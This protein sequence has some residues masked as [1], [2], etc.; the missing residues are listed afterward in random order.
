M[1]EGADRG[2]GNWRVLRDDLVESEERETLGIAGEWVERAHRLIA[3]GGGKHL[4]FSPIKTKR[5]SANGLEII[6]PV[7]I[8]SS[9]SGYLYLVRG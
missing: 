6:F 5:L 8:E 1:E 9:P 7:S 4:G 3:I 2:T